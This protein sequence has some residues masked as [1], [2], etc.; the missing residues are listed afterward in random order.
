MLLRLIYR[1]L[2]NRMLGSVFNIPTTAMM[3]LT[4]LTLP[5]SIAI[6]LT[7]LTGAEEEIKVACSLRTV[8]GWIFTGSLF[9]STFVALLFKSDYMILFQIILKY[10]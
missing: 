10:F 2:R 1:L 5:V 4:G 3:I 9:V 7:L 8:I 6:N